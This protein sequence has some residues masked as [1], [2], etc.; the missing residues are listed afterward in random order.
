[1]NPGDRHFEAKLTQIT[2]NRRGSILMLI[3]IDVWRK[4]ERRK[5]RGR[6][7]IH[8]KHESME[9]KQI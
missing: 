4:S 2:E 8:G 1:M 3:Q 6:G 5:K 7:E 9:F